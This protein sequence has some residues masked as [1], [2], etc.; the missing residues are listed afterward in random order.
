VKLLAFQLPV[1]CL[2]VLL[3]AGC[4]GSTDI[5]ISS[6]GSGL[7][8]LKRNDNFDDAINVLY[9]LDEFNPESA[10]QKVF[11]HLTQWGRDLKPVKNWQPDPLTAT[12]PASFIKAQMHRDLARAKPSDKTSSAMK[13]SDVQYL[14]ET[15]WMRSISRWLID[16]PPGPD[17]SMWLPEKKEATIFAGEAASP[18]ERAVK[19]FDWTVR[20]IQLEPAVTHPDYQRAAGPVKDGSQ[21]QAPAAMQGVTGPGYTQMP[22]EAMLYG[23]GDWL[24]RARVFI[25]LGRQADLDI[26]M[27]GFKDNLPD[28]RPKEWIP[29]VYIDGQLYLFDTRLGLPIPGPG[30]KGI[31]TLEDVTADPKLLSS[32][33]VKIP[34]GGDSTYPVTAKEL[35]QVIAMVDAEPAAIS[36]RMEIVQRRLTGDQKMQVTVSPTEIAAKVKKC[37]GINKVELW[38]TPYE[39]VMFRAALPLAMQK[40]S[41]L[42]YENQRRKILFSGFNQLLEARYK[43]FRG[44]LAPTPDDPGAKT[45]YLNSRLTDKELSA[46]DKDPAVQR[47]LGMGRPPKSPERRAMFFS[48]LRQVWSLAKNDAS[49]WLALAHFDGGDYAAAGNWFARVAKAETKIL[50]GLDDAA[51]KAGN[52][53]R[54]WYGAMY[55]QA[56]AAEAQGEYAKARQFLYELPDSPQVEGNLIRARL[57]IQ[58]E[59]NAAGTTADTPEEDTP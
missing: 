48:F 25:L 41:K 1:F 35:G 50:E 40:N 20:S 12:T 53:P 5:E 36:H 2:G 11:Y 32:L 39:A 37:K 56:R 38:R 9:R 30:G 29:A 7:G 51:R 10:E 4:G 49:Y 27:L 17:I 31:A 47:R 52:R 18:L 43:H 21:E 54:W 24:Q 28:S 45:L 23:T 59:S 33:D 6:Q 58:Q 34:G 55:N 13:L 3:L 46:V 14:R 8:D 22:W 57:L 42:A 15:M 16:Q 26:V 19:L 44:A